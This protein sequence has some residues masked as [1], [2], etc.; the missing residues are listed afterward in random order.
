M[1]MIPANLNP[2]RNK[3]HTSNLQRLEYDVLKRMAVRL[4]LTSGFQKLDCVKYI[5]EAL[6]DPYRI[7]SW[8]SGFKPY[9]LIFLQI[10]KEFGGESYPD[11]L[12]AM[13][14]ASGVKLPGSQ[15]NYFD[16]FDQVIRRLS[17]A[18]LLM[19]RSENQY[20][21]KSSRLSRYGSYVQLLYTDP[22]ILDQVGPAAL[23][24]LMLPPVPASDNPCVFLP[25]RV[26]M[27]LSNVIR[28]IEE[29]N[30]LNL[31]LN[32]DV[33]SAEYRRLDRQMGWKGG[34][35]ADDTL[36]LP[37]ASLFFINLLR[38]V[39]VLVPVD[40]VLRVSPK[41]QEFLSLPLTKQVR[42]LFHAVLYEV[43]WKEQGEKSRNFYIENYIQ[44]RTSFYYLLRSLPK[45]RLVHYSFDALDQALFER[46]GEVFS[47]VGFIYRPYIE[48]N[49]EKREDLKFIR[50]LAE[51]RQNWITTEKLWLESVV[52][53]WVY[54]LGMVSLGF[55]ASG[56]VSVGL[57]E[58][59]QAVLH[60]EMDRS[61]QEAE[62]R[63]QWQTAW[64]VQPN[65][66]IVVYLDRLSTAQLAFLERHADRQHSQ[67]HV[68]EYRL[69]RDSVYRGLESGTS[70]EDLLM[71]LEKGFGKDLPQNVIIEIREWASQREKIKLHRKA[72]LVE[73]TDSSARQK[74]LMNGL[75]GTLVGDRFLL[76]SALPEK[77]LAKLFKPV[78]DYANVR[79][80]VFNLSEHGVI[81]FDPSYPDLITKSRLIS[82]TTVN[83]K[84]ELQLTPESVRAAV[85]KGGSLSQLI[86]LLTEQSLTLIP[87]ILQIALR[88]WTGEQVGVRVEHI[89]VLRTDSYELGYAIQ[90]SP[91]LKPLIMGPLTPGV[92][93]VDQKNIEELRSQLM[94][95][96]IEIDTSGLI[97][98]V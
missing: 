36:S 38:N 96:G 1:K 56:L 14:F 33:R 8:L 11:F 22:R 42:M 81:T 45:D 4:G 65:F 54:F 53:S 13:V 17:N 91:T 63:D 39:N 95:F 89:I 76:L 80:R 27:I 46:I 75:E 74:A 58:L 31:T 97:K 48:A 85:E 83:E 20:E 88:A 79:L 64:V 37:N 84:G 62:Q 32:G 10:L 21:K 93:L 94:K 44:A 90:N 23:E 98:S 41:A 52:S 16:P 55:D 18:G 12:K 78:I 29:I 3:Y 6:N 61:D 67:E 19:T 9:E 30:G 5:R 77:P 82:W 26:T 47:L 92:F 28:G 34:V 72:N 24:P 35:M 73:F 43:D 15:H 87:Q 49:T 2:N 50:W 57:T 59:G 40:Q 70:L 60:P 66:D 7:R 86:T 68:A 71:Y 25:H 69:T 51:R